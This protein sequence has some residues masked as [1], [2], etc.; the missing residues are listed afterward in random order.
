MV[1]VV[2]IELVIFSLRYK[3]LALFSFRINLTTISK[4]PEKNRVVY[5]AYRENERC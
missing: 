1:A 2:D 4:I 5:I 3:N